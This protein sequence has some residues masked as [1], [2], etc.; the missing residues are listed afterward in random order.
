[1][2]DKGKYYRITYNNEG[3]YEALHKKV[4]INEWKSLLSSDN[5]TWLPKPKIYSS[6]NKSYFTDKGYNKFISEV[7]PIILKYFDK[8][9]IKIE[10]INSLQ[11]IIY[12]D[13]YQIIIEIKK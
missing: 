2:N 1:M 9:D 12:K 6:E 13:E 5:F 3:I 7:Y 11:N 10:E 8:D 4:S